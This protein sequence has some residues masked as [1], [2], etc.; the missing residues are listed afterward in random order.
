MGLRRGNSLGR[1]LLGR[2]DRADRCEARRPTLAPPRHLLQIASHPAVHAH[3]LARLDSLFGLV[4]T[5]QRTSTRRRRCPSV[6]PL[7]LRAQVLLGHAHG[8][9]TP[10]ERRAHLELRQVLLGLHPALLERSEPDVPLHRAVPRVETR[11]RPPCPLHCFAYA[12]ISSAQNPLQNAPVRLVH[13]QVEL[14]L[15]R[16]LLEQHV[17]A[18]HL[19]E[20]VH[21]L[22]L[23]R[24]VRLGHE[25]RH[26]GRDPR[27][28]RLLAATPPPRLPRSYRRQ[29]DPLEILL[30]LR[31]QPEHEVE[32]QLVP[33]HVQ[34]TLR[35]LRNLL[36]GHVL[37]D[38]IAHPL[39]PRLRRER[40]PRRSHLAKPLQ[41]FCRQAVRSQRRHPQRHMTRPQTTRKLV[42]Q[43]ANVRVVRGGQRGQ[44]DLVIAPHTH[45]FLDRLHQPRRIAIALRPEDHARLAKA[46]P[47]HAAA[48]H[49]DRQPLE[50]RLRTARRES[51]RE[52]V[53]LQIRN[54]RAVHRHRNALVQR[55]IDDHA[56]VRWLD[57]R[58]VH[59]RDVHAVDGGQPPQTLDTRHPRPMIRCPST[60][61]LHGDSLTVA[62]RERIEERRHRLRVGRD[63]STP[64][65]QG[66]VLPSL[67]HSQRDSPQIEQRQAVGEHQLVLQRHAH[68]VELA[69]RVRGLERQ[70]RQ[71][72][73]AKLPLHVMPR[74]KRPLAQHI[75]L[76]VEHVVQDARAQMAHADVVD[77][78]ER[79][80]HAR[81]H[82]APRLARLARL[83]TEVARGL[84]DLMQERRVGVQSQRAGVG[85]EAGHGRPRV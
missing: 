66:L 9:V 71:T 48:R 12:S 2:R 34:R 52:W 73:L 74:R 27:G 16:P 40:Q 81:L 68:D 59:R 79:E 22:P 85:V 36:L 56:A 64:E 46:T 4:G 67:G 29:H 7:P 25:R 60:S 15:P 78:R 83:T 58:G 30:R 41:H 11:A 54:Q 82:R 32:L 13:L 72:A 80:A 23:Q 38:Q 44:R 26:R 61:D 76:R 69:Q 28:P 55:T 45:R 53:L 8:N 35:R 43:I 49:L 47:L 6:G 51:H 57:A 77:V 21:P 14:A 33:P 19:L 24:R 31:R 3:Q 18:P 20:T 1:R 84:L 75:G 62:H 50:D 65:H 63:R 17:L 42:D 5:A 37:V 39:R 10:R 70:Q